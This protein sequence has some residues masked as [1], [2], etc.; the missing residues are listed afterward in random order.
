MVC[1]NHLMSANI[2]SITVTEH[3][4][5]GFTYIS[6]NGEFFKGCRRCGGTGHYSFNGFDSI[7]YACGNTAAKLGDAFENEAAAQK[8]CHER[9]VRKA[10][11][12]RKR[13]AAQQLKIDAA[14]ANSQALLAAD[15]EVHA[16]LMS[17]VIED[18]TQANFA[19][20]EEWSA[21][22][23]PVKLEKD[24]FIRSMAE[25]LR[26]V[27]Q[28]KAFTPNMIAAVRK[29]MERRQ[30]QAIEA[31]AHPAPSGRVA[32]T[33]EITSTKVVDGDYG[34]TYKM[35]VKSDEGFKV[36]CSIPAA[37]L[38]TTTPEEAK[39]RRITFTAT[40]QPTQDDPSFAFGSRPSKGAWL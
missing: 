19:T 29:T 26:W 17:I 37:L 33:G 20:Y 16:F 21:Q 4:F 13:A 7:C 11:A 38:E 8:W 30:A 2:S 27:G 10:Q 12:D 32:V 23:Q 14:E 36:W 31:A 39:G 28:S 1:N 18:D 34:T 15:P 5:K 24:I 35:L 25:A 40:L 9:S 3:E 22:A 6:Y